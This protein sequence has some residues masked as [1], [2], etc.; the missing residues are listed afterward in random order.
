VYVTTIK[1]QQ[2]LHK[3]RIHYQNPN[4]FFWNQTQS[5]GPPPNIHKRQ[6]SN[7]TLRTSHPASSKLTV[8]CRETEYNHT[9][10]TI[11]KTAFV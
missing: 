8:P 9:T 3:S 1:L 4:T 7:T 11:K 6:I 2:Y 10:N 5:A